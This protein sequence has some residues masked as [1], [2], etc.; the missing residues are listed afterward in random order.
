MD[1]SKFTISSAITSLNPISLN[2]TQMAILFA[3][4]KPAKEIIQRFLLDKNQIII[5]MEDL[6]FL[7]G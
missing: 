3:N 5:K 6:V 4:S 1:E 7:T 2:N